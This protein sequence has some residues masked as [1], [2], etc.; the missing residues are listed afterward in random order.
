MEGDE[1][2]LFVDL[3]AYCHRSLAKLPAEARA[4]YRSRVDGQAERW[5]QR[6]TDQP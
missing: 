4:I 2:V 6:G 3:R 5:Y 1:F